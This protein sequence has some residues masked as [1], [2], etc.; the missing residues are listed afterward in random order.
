MPPQ[1]PN[2]LTGLRLLRVVG[3][4]QLQDAPPKRQLIDANSGEVRRVWRPHRERHSKMSRRI[5]SEHE[6]DGARFRFH[7]LPGLIWGKGSQRDPKAVAFR[8]L[9]LDAP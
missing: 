6:L 5:E 9:L 8:F 1:S 3:V 2:P 7:L 4:E